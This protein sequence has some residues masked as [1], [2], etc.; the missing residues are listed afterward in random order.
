MVFGWDDILMAAG[1]A[2]AS[3]VGQEV[4]KGI[5]GGESSASGG[6]AGGQTGDSIVN[7]MANLVKQ[8]QDS[9]N[10][11]KTDQ[12][13]KQ[14]A[15]MLAKALQ[16]QPPQVGVGMSKIGLGDSNPYLLDF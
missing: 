10:K 7:L 3:T 14:R 8:Y 5:F 9:E 13:N 15:D 12:A 2:L 1:T 16:Y 6:Q 4:G 11:R